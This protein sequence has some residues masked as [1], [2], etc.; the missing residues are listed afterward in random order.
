MRLFGLIGYPLSHSFSERYFT[1]K[2]AKERLAD[3][4][5]RLFP[6]NPLQKIKTLLQ[7]YPQ[8]EGLNVTIPYKQQVL[9]YLDARTG[10]PAALNACNCIHIKKGKLTGYNTDYTAFQKSLAPH[11]RPPHQKA[12]ILGNGGAAAAVRFALQQLGISHV[13]VS[14]RVQDDFTLTYEQLDQTIINDCKLIINTTPLGMYPDTGS[15]PA[16]PY[17]YLTRDHFLYDLVYNPMKTIFLRK[18]EERGAFI[19][20]GEEM[21]VLQAEESWRIWN[22]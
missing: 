3:C 12:L 13:T 10:I 16:I 2:F 15:F 5:Y 21:L 6:I 1:E 17:S 11:L 4:Q 9:S 22:S 7:Q 19:K 8:L 18:A 14:R 20:N